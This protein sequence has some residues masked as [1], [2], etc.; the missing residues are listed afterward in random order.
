MQGCSINR[1]HRELTSILFS[2]TKIFILF[3]KDLQTI[4]KPSNCVWSLFE[5]EAVNETSQIVI[6]NRLKLY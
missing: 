5:D 2:S 6:V 4:T 1:V 3:S